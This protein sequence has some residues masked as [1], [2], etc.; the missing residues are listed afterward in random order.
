LD[1]RVQNPPPEN[2]ADSSI[3][4]LFHQLIDDGRSL[5]GAEV[6]LYKQIALYRAS[7]AKNGIIAIV[8]AVFLLNAALVAAMV[9]LVIGLADLIGPVAGGL[10]VLAAV[11]AIGFLLVRYGAGK[12][13]ALGGDAD[14][15]RAL[16]AG[17]QR[18]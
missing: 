18:S 12:L 17:E 1:V 4:D 15:K 3:S 13:S 11:G 8:A 16:K 14:E 2:P 7:K 5:V 9:G 10:A 6:N